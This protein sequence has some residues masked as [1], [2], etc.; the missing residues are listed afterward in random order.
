MP[1]E[2]TREDV[3]RV[4]ALVG[5][6]LIVLGG[7]ALPFYGVERGTVD[8]DIEVQTTTFEEIDAI[9]A[10]L[11]AAGVDGDVSGN[12]SGWGM[13]PLPTGYRERAIAT[14][15]PHIRVLEPIDFIHSKL[16]RGTREDLGDCL[17]VSGAQGIH[18]TQIRERLE[19]ID[20]PADPISKE[21]LKRLERLCS[22]LEASTSG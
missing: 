16:R 21:Y 4:A 5:K 18:A 12:A 17:A 9:D 14:D 2:I 13:I 7:A 19:L 20:L 22:E 6:P 10:R 8:I 15:I 1:H 3:E 11:K